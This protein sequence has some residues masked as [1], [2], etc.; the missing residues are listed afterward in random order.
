MRFLIA[1][2][3]FTACEDASPV[4]PDEGVSRD[5]FVP[6][7]RPDLDFGRLL[8][9][10]PAASP[11]ADGSR[12]RP[13][14]TV[15]E[16][17][18]AARTGDV[19]LLLAGTYPPPLLPPDGVE[20]LGAGP[21]EVV[22]DGGL[23]VDRPGAV[24]GGFT[25]RGGVAVSA[26]ASLHDIHV[27]DAPAD[28]FLVDADVTLHRCAVRGA[29]G[30]GV[31]AA[32]ANLTIDELSISDT[33]AFGVLAEGGGH[34]LERVEVRRATAA[35]L[36]FVGGEASV[37]QLL[38]V[39]TRYSEEESTGSGVGF[40]GAR[41][42][43][44]SADIRGGDRGV[45]ISMESV[46][47]LQD[48]FV[49]D[50]HTGVNVSNG[51]TVEARAVSVARA[52]GG[53]FNVVDGHATLESLLVREGGRVGLLV[54][55][56]VVDA[57]DVTV[58]GADARGISLLQASGALRSVVVRD[59]PNVGIQITDPSGAIRLEEVLVERAANGG[60]AVLG[61]AAEGTVELVD[62]HVDGTLLGSDD[63]AAGIHL[64]DTAATLERPS[65]SSNVG[66]GILA[67]RT[68]LSLRDASLQGN[69]GPGL[70][71]LE[72]ALTTVVSGGLARDNVGSG[73]LFIGGG[74]D[75]SAVEVSGSSPLLGE[76]DGDGIAAGFEAR[77][78]V[79]QAVLH[80]NRGSG[81]SVVTFSAARI[82]GSRLEDNG[83]YGIRVGCDGSVVEEPAENHFSG[84]ADGPRS[85][86]Q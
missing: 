11:D 77:L 10:S 25:V 55:S 5:A 44:S 86:C 74:A 68:A 16:A 17:Y 79:R 3:L 26:P 66:P 60:V 1:A 27:Q 59:A 54:S 14:R 35:G 19:V 58:E 28:G 84:N 85:V 41:G 52:P 57:S 53:G 47:A 29:R 71:V 56:S 30:A 37:R 82:S 9:V 76:G 63:L 51:S 70:V 6:I 21:E 48:V 2:L 33:G 61:G 40:V 42:T 49:R 73:M 20:L 18:E 78:T 80:D 23:S 65:A 22:I 69:G 36:R 67:E 64:Y 43:V 83:A 38:V 13:F 46:V 72:P 50:A 31:R 62:V 4:R 15:T 24:T 7:V 39:G 75:I 45:R 32:D 12:A 8:H 81:L 34:Q